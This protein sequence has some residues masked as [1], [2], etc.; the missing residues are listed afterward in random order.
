MTTIAYRSGYLAADTL[1]AYPNITNG[2]REKISRCGNYLVAMAGATFI[3]DV[4]EEWVSKGCDSEEVPSVL[5]D[6]ADKFT[7]L[8]VDYSGRAH[9][10]DNGFL[11][12]IFADYTAMGSGALLAMGA[13][14]HGATSAQAV[15][16]AAK[17]DKS[18]G[19]S[20]SVYHYSY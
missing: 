3:R 9:E 15:E 4:L 12:P 18:T 6:H 19:G 17:H 7:A 20:V 5:L 13:M 16:A 10:F 1:I 11:T 14:A 2:S 8:I